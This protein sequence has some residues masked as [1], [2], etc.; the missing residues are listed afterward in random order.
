M[1][2]TITLE[3]A[4]MWALLN[5]LELYGRIAMGQLE[6]LLDVIKHGGGDR[7]TLRRLLW[8][9]KREM[10]PHMPLNAYFGI[11]SPEVP[12]RAKAAYDLYQVVRHAKSWAEHP[13]GGNTTWFHDPF[14]VCRHPL[15][16]VD[17]LTLAPDKVV[18][19]GAES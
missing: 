19:D 12:E 11:A 8:A 5:A 4:H 16:V 14:K 7:N 10:M 3:D 1:K 13:E 6:E 18:A 9:V 2:F 15:P 17:G